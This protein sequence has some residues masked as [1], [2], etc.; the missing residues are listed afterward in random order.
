MASVTRGQSPPDS[1]MGR[2]MS[3]PPSVVVRVS[4]AVH[5][6]VSALKGRAVIRPRLRCPRYKHDECEQ[7]HSHGWIS[8]VMVK[9]RS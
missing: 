1:A 4:C 9:G 6:G 5:A 7:D 8:A 2:P 3:M